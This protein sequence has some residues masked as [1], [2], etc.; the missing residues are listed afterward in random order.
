MKC[1][2]CPGKLK[3]V[4]VT[5]AGCEGISL[6]EQG[7]AEK[8]PQPVQIS[9]AYECLQCGRTYHLKHD[10]LKGSVI[11]EESRVDAKP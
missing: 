10:P 8:Q 7:L 9:L 4:I 6:F 2:Y 11:V 3:K 1:F 5:Y